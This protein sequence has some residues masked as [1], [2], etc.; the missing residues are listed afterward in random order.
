M[1]RLLILGANGFIGQ[2]LARAGEAEL[3]LVRAD[4]RPSEGSGL[5]LVDI[6]NESDVRALIA[7]V[8]PSHV[9]LLAAL[10]DIDLCER[11][12]ER[13]RLLNTLAPTWVASAC[14]E[15]GARLL[16]TSS[17][18]VFD[19]ESEGYVESD[20]VSPLSVYG[21][22]KAEAE[23]AIL[24]IDPNAVVVRIALAI[25]F[26][27]DKETNALYNKAAATLRA[28]KSLAAPTFERRN[29]IDAATLARIALSC[30]QAPDVTGLLHVGA[31]S[32]IS[33]FDLLSEFARRIG[34]DPALITAQSEPLPGRAPR[35]RCHFLRTE[36]LAAICPVPVP[37]LQQVIERSL[38]E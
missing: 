19:G 29:P 37:T 14:R 20:P 18:A 27:F 31:A 4:N 13:A 35:G 11:E 23:R 10:S 24:D 15:I 1:P 30:L 5:T 36:R 8:R 16:F 7:S 6:T 3:E 26:A 25:G 32:D 28:G 9:A 2:H 34:C 22:S 21:R 33:R 17:A 38:E 12:P